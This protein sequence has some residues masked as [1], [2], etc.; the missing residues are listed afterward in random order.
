MKAPATAA[1]PPRTKLTLEVEAAPGVSAAEDVD[2][3]PII[4]LAYRVSGFMETEFL[5]RAGLGRDNTVCSSDNIEGS[6][7]GSISGSSWYHCWWGGAG[8]NGCN[9][10]IFEGGSQSNG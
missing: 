5:T 2:A 3:A 1:I 4:M 6:G 10:T 7:S 9:G 8:T